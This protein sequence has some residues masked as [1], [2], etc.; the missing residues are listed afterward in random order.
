[1]PDPLLRPISRL[2][3][4]VSCPVCAAAESWCSSCRPD[5]A[6]IRSALPGVG[7]VTAVSRYEGGLAEAIR[8][9]K[10]R[11]RRDLT[12]PLSELLTAAVAAWQPPD[13]PVALVPVPVRP[14][15]RRRRGRDVV[16]ELAAQVA[17]ALP[18]LHLRRCLRWHRRV[19]DQVGAGAAERS[20][21]V[22]GAM[23]C[24]GPQP[25]PVIVLDDVSTTGATLAEAARA[26]R[27][28]GAGPVA[29]AVL[30]ASAGRE[31]VREQCAR[32]DS[33]VVRPESS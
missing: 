3:W 18:W 11:G 28:A 23:A 25:G 9:W 20:R 26:L 12:G 33:V 10:L 15:S 7:P 5:G 21:N 19:G 13:G 32:E 29:A 2:L 14:A 24:R 27:H 8:A 22:A 6:P 16:G 4:P 1:V 30:A 31:S 17:E